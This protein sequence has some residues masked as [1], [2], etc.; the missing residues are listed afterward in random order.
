MLLLVF[1]FQ[2]AK[3]G[4]FGGLFFNEFVVFALKHPKKIRLRRADVQ[5]VREQMEISCFFLQ[6][7]REQMGISVISYQMRL[8]FTVSLQIVREQMGIWLKML[9]L[10][11]KMGTHLF[12]RI[13]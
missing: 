5:Y 4:L 13:L 9:A 8:F 11:T 2:K 10:K 3:F 7:F 6:L 1:F 12:A